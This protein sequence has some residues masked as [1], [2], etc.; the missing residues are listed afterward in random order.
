MLTWHI[1]WRLWRHLCCFSIT[2]PTTT[3][4]VL[5]NKETTTPKWVVLPHRASLTWY[6]ICKRPNSMQSQCRVSLMSSATLITTVAAMCGL[7]GI[8]I[9]GVLPSIVEVGLDTMLRPVEKEQIW[10]LTLQGWQSTIMTRVVIAM[11][12]KTRA[13]AHS[14][15]FPTGAQIFSHRF[16]YLNL[17]WKLLL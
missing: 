3:I 6:L 12:V 8:K 14:L 4:P 16:Y 1:W 15:N 2:A 17:N 13:P 11:K 10:H 5:T 9:C 7:P